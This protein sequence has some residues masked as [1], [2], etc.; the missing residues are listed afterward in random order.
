MYLL[1]R[2]ASAEIYIYIYIFFPRFFVKKYI[3]LY[4]LRHFEFREFYNILY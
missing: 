4:K 3:F 1:E 2:S